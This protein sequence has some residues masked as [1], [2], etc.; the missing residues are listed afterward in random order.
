[1]KTMVSNTSNTSNKMCVLIIF[2]KALNDLVIVQNSLNDFN[3]FWKNDIFSTP[4]NDLV[5]P[6]VNQSLVIHIV[7]NWIRAARGSYHS[8]NLYHPLCD[9]PNTS[10]EEYAEK[11][12]NKHFMTWRLR[13]AAMNCELS[14]SHPREIH[15]PRVITSDLHARRCW[16][17]NTEQ[18][19]KMRPEA[20]L[21][22][23]WTFFLENFLNTCPS[24]K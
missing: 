5:E 23:F 17:R 3:N 14:L 22:E 7:Y 24:R 4:I 8:T 9:L 21:R 15:F 19:Q 6:E 16:I 2:E 18:Q 1:M 20:L 12:K 10:H 13:P 11:L